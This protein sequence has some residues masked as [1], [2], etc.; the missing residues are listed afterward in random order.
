M[1]LPVIATNYSGPTAYLT[2]ANSYPLRIEGVDQV[3]SPTAA[4]RESTSATDH[5]TDRSIGRPTDSSTHR[6]TDQ[7]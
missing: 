1:G 4:L 7:K 5:P 6:I 2:E 3:H